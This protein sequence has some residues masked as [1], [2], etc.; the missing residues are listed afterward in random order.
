MYKYRYVIDSN[1]VNTQN[2]GGTADVDS[3]SV[4]LNPLP[5]DSRFNDLNIFF[6]I[7]SFECR[8]GAS[9]TLLAV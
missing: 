8:Q 1:Q 6:G 2:F 9:I 5:N 3:K 4:S 7:S